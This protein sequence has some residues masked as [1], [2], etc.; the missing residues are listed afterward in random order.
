MKM[1]LEI[2]LRSCLA[3]ACLGL[4]VWVSVVEDEV[5][6]QVEDINDDQVEMA[7]NVDEDAVVLD[8]TRAGARLGLG[9]SFV[10]VVV[11]EVVDEYDLVLDVK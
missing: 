8:A 10:E 7:E 5:E 6:E 9:A 11:E 3:G 2:L 4:W 1:F